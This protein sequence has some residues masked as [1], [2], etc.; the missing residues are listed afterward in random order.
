M[1]LLIL[2]FAF[3]ILHFAVSSPLK[4]Q[5]QEA[6]VGFYL[7]NLYG[8]NMDEHSF[9]ADFYVW[10]KWRGDIDPTN[11]EFVNSIEKWSMA[12]AG[13]DGDSTPVVLKDGTKYKI[14]RKEGRFFH[15]FSLNRFPLD[16]HTLDIQIE[17]PE[18]PS[19][20]LLYV[21]DTN[22]AIIRSTLNLVGW[23]TRNCQLA[24]RV[25]DYGS[26]FGNPEENAQRYSNLSFNITLARPFSYFL[27][28][29]LLPLLVVMLVG[30]GALLLHP[31]HIDTRSSLP[32]GA[33][34]TAVFLQQSYSNA[35]PDT[36][37]MVLMDKIYLLSYLL[38][39][40]VLLQ[41]IRSGNVTAK[42]KVGAKAIVR[43]ERRLAA[44]Y[45]AVFVLGV[46][47]LSLV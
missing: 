18:Y 10:F 23:E 13:F 41:I 31:K 22:A 32:I 28:K 4:A 20:S 21:P 46:V 43:R 3:Y 6:Q 11:I 19:D 25:H 35:L 33:L 12:T 27:L 39:S 16:K 42:E 5:P 24:T 47:V 7:M 2:H 34:L 14:F 45:L 38:I 29:M 8:L 1:R 9:Y 40:L 26:N 15:A 30:I 17:N 36:G 37:Y 44:I